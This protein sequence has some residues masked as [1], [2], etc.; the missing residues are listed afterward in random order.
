MGGMHVTQTSEL[1][2]SEEM[3]SCDA[4]SMLLFPAEVVITH[5]LHDGTNC[6]MWVPIARLGHKKLRW[7][8]KNFQA[9]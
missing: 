4:V 7:H 5:L 1:L 2:S 3:N 6:A 8:I 9:Y